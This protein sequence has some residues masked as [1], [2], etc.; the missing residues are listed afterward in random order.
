MKMVTKEWLENMP[1]QGNPTSDENHLLS[2][3]IEHSEM[4][5]A[6]LSAKISETTAK[7]AIFQESLEALKGLISFQERATPML[8]V[9]IASHRNLV[10]KSLS[11]QTPTQADTKSNCYDT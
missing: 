1:N 9:H 7:R 8:Y 4:T 11:S 6:E 2:P 10:L 5:L 3:T